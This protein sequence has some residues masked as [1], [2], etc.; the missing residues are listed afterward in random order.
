M[1]ELL[2]NLERLELIECVQEY[3]FAKGSEIY[4]I[5]KFVNLPENKGK[6]R[7]QLEYEIV[8]KLRLPKLSKS[9]F[10]KTM[11]MYN[12]ILPRLMSND[13]KS[14]IDMLN[15]Q[16]SENHNEEKSNKTLPVKIEVVEQRIRKWMDMKYDILGL[17][18]D[19]EI[20]D[21]LFDIEMAIFMNQYLFRT[22]TFEDTRNQLSDA[23][24][25]SSVDKI[26]EKKHGK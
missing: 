2:T 17:P 15:T 3:G 13:V 21:K 26:L 6:P 19:D 23:F 5:H 7:R 25:K 10:D 24:E 1:G 18:M 14:K 22:Y 12:K 20:R 11:G 16:S 4:W 9:T 8:E